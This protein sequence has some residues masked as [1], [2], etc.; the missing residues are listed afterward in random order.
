MWVLAIGI[1][2]APVSTRVACFV[3]VLHGPEVIAGITDV[4]DVGSRFFVRLNV[5]R[6]FAFQARELSR[7]LAAARRVSL[8]GTIN[9]SSHWRLVPRVAQA[10]AARPDKMARNVY[11]AIFR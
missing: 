5:G 1:G 4:V 8:R 10:P 7:L 11:Q 3:I 2:R 6:K 9:T